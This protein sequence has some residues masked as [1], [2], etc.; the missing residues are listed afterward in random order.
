MPHSIAIQCFAWS[1]AITWDF[2]P[3][4]R[5]VARHVKKQKHANT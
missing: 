5:F 1:R 2:P 4:T 3:K